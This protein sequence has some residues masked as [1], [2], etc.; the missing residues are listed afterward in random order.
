MKNKIKNYVHPYVYEKHIDN[1]DFYK[2]N[3]IRKASNVQVYLYQMAKNK[4]NA[5]LMQW[6]FII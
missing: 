2:K 5:F 1:V 6:V 3:Q 4:A